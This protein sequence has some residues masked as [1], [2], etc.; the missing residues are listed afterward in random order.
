MQAVSEFLTMG[1]YGVYVWPSYALAVLIMGGMLGVTLARLRGTKRE[2]KGYEQVH[3]A[4]R[5]RRGRGGES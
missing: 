2:L 4:H 5:K 1:G 3:A